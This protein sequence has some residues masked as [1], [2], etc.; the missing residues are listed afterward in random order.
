MTKAVEQQQAI[1]TSL[2][3]ATA[4]FTTATTLLGNPPDL[5]AT[6]TTLK[7]RVAKANDA[8]NE[9][10]TELKKATSAASAAVAALTVAQEKNDIERTKLKPLKDVVQQHRA[11][12]VLAL[13]TSQ[14]AF[15]LVTHAEQNVDWFEQLLRRNE[16]EISIPKLQA[17]SVAAQE[18]QTTAT[19][20]IAAAKT[21]LAA[22]SKQSEIIKDEHDA[23]VNTLKQ[24]TEHMQTVQRANI[25]LT[26]ALEKSKSAAEVL[27]NEDMTSITS[28][29]TQLT[30]RSAA[31]ISETQ[32]QLSQ[33]T[34]QMTATSTAIDSLQAKITTTRQKTE[35]ARLSLSLIHI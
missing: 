12:R 4:R 26:E 29:L 28:R 11:T 16:A 5:T 34:E 15:E 33:Q 10:T 8:L 31:T 2:T 6:A 7:A 22:M 18:D 27:Q 17:K 1:A 30:A 9:Q 20:T 23:T 35:S 24:L 14:Q 13:K 21:Q 3:E 25:L 32:Q 19:A